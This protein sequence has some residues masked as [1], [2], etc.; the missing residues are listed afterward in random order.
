[1]NRLPFSENPNGSYYYKDSTLYF[2]NDAGQAIELESYKTK[3]DARQVCQHR[4]NWL[5][6][7]GCGATELSEAKLP[8][9]CLPET[10][11][12]EAYLKLFS[13]FMPFEITC[14]DD[15][16]TVQRRLDS[17]IDKKDHTPEDVEYMS[18]LGSVIR[19]YE[20]CVLEN[21]I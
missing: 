2:V 16:D 8:K 11:D 5:D 17:I 15:Y 19:F 6:G 10:I 7:V 1:M 9:Q 13:E 12:R 20:D 4:N 21:V 14:Q 18:I 3:A